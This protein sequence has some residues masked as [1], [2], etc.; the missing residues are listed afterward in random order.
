MNQLCLRAVDNAIACGN[1]AIAIIHVVVSDGESLLI[2]APETLKESFRSQHAGCGD[3]RIIPG[4]LRITQIAVVGSGGQLKSGAGHSVVISMH[5][6]SMLNS[7]V[8]Q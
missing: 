1:Q 3:R 4:Y 7:P 5:N 8:C 6:P 2:K